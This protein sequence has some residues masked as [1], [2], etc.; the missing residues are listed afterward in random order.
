MALPP[1]APLSDKPATAV[2]AH[3]AVAI[4]AEASL[5]SAEVQKSAAVLLSVAAVVL[6][7]V[8]TGLHLAPMTLSNGAI[9][10]QI[11]TLLVCSQHKSD[12]MLSACPNAS[13]GHNVCGN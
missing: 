8:N 3:P 9:C 7:C 1:A 6:F 2:A 5:K 10:R 12:L 13:P 4:W 11:Q